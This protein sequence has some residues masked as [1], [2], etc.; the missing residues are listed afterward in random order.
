MISKPFT[1]LTILPNYANGHVVTW[2]IDPTIQI[3][4][5]HTFIFQTAGSPMFEEILAEKDVGNVFFAVDDSN[6]KQSSNSDI[7]Y[8][9]KLV[10]LKDNTEYCSD[11]IAFQPKK[12]DR[13]SYLYSR[14]IARKEILRFKLIGSVGAVLKRKIYGTHLA[15]DVDPISG[16]PLTDNATSQGTLFETGYY[17]PLLIMM[18]IEDSQQVRKLSQD[19]MGVLDSTTSTLRTVGF[20][21]IETYDVIVDVLSDKRYIVKDM[22]KMEYPSSNLTI[23]QT[24]RV[25]LLPPTDPVYKIKIPHVQL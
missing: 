3:S 4:P 2:A 6:L 16:I 8:R 24:L 22:E 1:S 15:E 23:V 9:V 25:Q 20:P 12:Y 13:R 17:D 7:Y 18:S 19:G 21:I 11:A 10:D 5:N 14:E